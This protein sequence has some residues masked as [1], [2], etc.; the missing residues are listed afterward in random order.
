[1][2]G[3]K[4]RQALPAIVLLLLASAPPPPGA[5][6]RDVPAAGAERGALL[7]LLLQA[8]GDGGRPVPARPPRRD[9]V[10][11]R[12]YSGGGAP[13]PDPRAIAAAAPPPPRLFAAARHGGLLG[14]VWEIRAVLGMGACFTFW[15]MLRLGQGAVSLALAQVR[16]GR[17]TQGQFR[18]KPSCL[19]MFTDSAWPGDQAAGH[20]CR[21]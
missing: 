11:S 2:R 16:P 21:S 20:L 6:G 18:A 19:V 12:R 9:R 1:M 8:L 7:D 17:D 13:P 4:K 5:E 10:I 14:Q 15:S 3:A